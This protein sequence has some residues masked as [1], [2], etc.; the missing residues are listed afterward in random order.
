[1]LDLCACVQYR[2][3]Y[4]FFPLQKMPLDRFDLLIKGYKKTVHT[5]AYW[6]CLWTTEN[7]FFY[8]KSRIK[9]VLHVQR[10]HFTLTIALGT[11]LEHTISSTTTPLSPT[12]M[13]L[14]TNWYTDELAANHPLLPPD[15]AH[16]CREP[17]HGKIQLGY[18]KCESLN[19]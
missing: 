19:K 1:M 15:S 9:N 13:K 18:K 16:T 7:M 11:S 4:C 12:Q 3:Q 6:E 10:I 8:W 14:L 2:Y 17:N 5:F